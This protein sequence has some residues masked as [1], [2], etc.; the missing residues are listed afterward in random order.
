V[1]G[2]GWVQMTNSQLGGCSYFGLGFVA[3]HWAW[4]SIAKNVY[5][6]LKEGL[7]LLEFLPMYMQCSY[8]K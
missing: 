2:I 8:N 6:I 3:G 4:I 5:I 1:D 7:T